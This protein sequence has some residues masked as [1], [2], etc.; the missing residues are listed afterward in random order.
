MRNSI[1][2]TVLFTLILFGCN[3][4]EETDQ[5]TSSKEN[6]S[7]TENNDGTFSG[8][9]AVTYQNQLSTD[10]TLKISDNNY[11][12][13]NGEKLTEYTLQASEEVTLDYHFE[14]ITQKMPAVTC[15]LPD[16]SVD[17]ADNYPLGYGYRENKFYCSITEQR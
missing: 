3:M 15:I 7:T 17:N 14:N 11:F 2:F 1:L 12:E 16:K 4:A 8:C 6:Y 10:C 13:L 9:W 5:T